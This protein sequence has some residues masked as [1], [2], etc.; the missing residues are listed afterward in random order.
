M[1]KLSK[2]K[3]KKNQ[4]KIARNKLHN[5]NRV[6]CTCSCGHTQKTT[7]SALSTTELCRDCFERKYHDKI[8]YRRSK[9]MPS[10]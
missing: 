7:I 4:K 8:M 6:T 3:S 2:K 10:E 1:T 5:N 9:R